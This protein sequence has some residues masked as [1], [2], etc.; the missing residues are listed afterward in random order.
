MK[1]SPLW[2][3]LVLVVPD[4]TELVLLLATEE[5]PDLAV[6]GGLSLLQLA[7]RRVGASLR[8]EQ[9]AAPLQELLDLCGLGAEV[10]G[11]RKAR[12]KPLGVEERMDRGDAL[13]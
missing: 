7:V 6:V 13:S 3:R 5:T 12:E 4:G 9:V 8:L 1:T 11:Q 10:A 2:A